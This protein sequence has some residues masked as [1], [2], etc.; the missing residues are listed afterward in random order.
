M[1]ERKCFGCGRFGNITHHCRNGEKERFV[2]MISNKFEV[3]KSRVMQKGEESRGEVKKDR[4]EILRE[5]RAKREVEVRQTKIERKEKKKKL[6]REVTV[7]IG[8]KQEKEEEE[9]IV[10]EALLDSGMTSLVMSEE[11]ARRYKFRRMKLERQIYVKNVDGMLNYARPIVD[12]VEVEIY[13]KRYKERMLIDMIRGQEWGVI[14]GMS[15]LA[16]YNPEIDWRTG[17]VQMTRCLE[18]YGKK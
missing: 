13:F 5:E 2:Q 9:E 7:K 6:L 14:L 17:E 18:E 16:Y 4:K 12:I 8:L 3:L 10:V 15:W 1:E 11:F